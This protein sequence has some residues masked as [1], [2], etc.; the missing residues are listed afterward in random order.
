VTG[1]REIA[2]GLGW[3]A[4]TGSPTTDLGWPDE[5]RVSRETSRL[6][7]T[8]RPASS[9]ST[10]GPQLRSEP[11]GESRSR[12]VGADA[13]A[14]MAGAPSAGGAS[15]VLDGVNGDTPVAAAGEE[16]SEQS[17]EAAVQTVVPTAAP[18]EEAPEVSAPEVSAPEVSV[19]DVPALQGTVSEGAVSEGAVSEESAPEFLAPGAE[20]TPA[21]AAPARCGHGRGAR[22]PH[23]H[24]GR[25]RSSRGRRCGGRRG[26]CRRRFT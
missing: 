13:H 17:K 12:A 22:W 11:S 8:G 7:A 6:Q 5:D 19:P 21:S 9:G 18:Q 25:P 4:L 15:A 2:R 10:D 23:D 14:P 16:Q 3:P 1:I 24:D 26:A 20:A